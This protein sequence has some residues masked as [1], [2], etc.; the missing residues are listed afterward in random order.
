MV[1]LPNIK[2]TAL[3]AFKTVTDLF[4]TIDDY[5]HTCAA[6]S[7]LSYQLENLTGIYYTNDRALG[8]EVRTTSG[9]VI[10]TYSDYRALYADLKARYTSATRGV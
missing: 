6:I 2:K 10:A 7:E 3:K 9:E 1:T 5:A 4:F 8:Y